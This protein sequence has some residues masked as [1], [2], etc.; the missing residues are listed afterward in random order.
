M[1]LTGDFSLQDV[2]DEFGNNSKPSPESLVQ[3][4]TDIFGSANPGDD[5]RNFTNT[6]QPSASFDDVINITSDSFQPELTVDA[7]GVL[8]DVRYLIATE[9]LTPELFSDEQDFLDSVD[10]T[11]TF[12]NVG[13]SI[14]A[15]TFNSFIVENLDDDTEYYIIAQYRNNFISNPLDYKTTW[16][17][18]NTGLDY[19]V[20]T[21]DTTSTTTTTVPFT[22]TIS[23]ASQTVN[24][25]VAVI[26]TVN[27]NNIPNDATMSYEV[28]SGGSDVSP[29]TGTFTITVTSG[30]T[31]T[32]NFSFN[33][34]ND[35]LTEGPESFDV[36]VSYLG[37]VLDTATLNINDTSTDTTTTTTTTL[38]PNY[39]S[40]NSPTTANE[41]Q[42]VTF[43]LQSTNIPDGTTVPYNTNGSTID[44][45]D[46]VT[47]S[48]PLSGT[49]TM[50]NNVGTLTFKLREDVLTEGSEKIVVNLAS[51][52]SNGI[53]D[54]LNV[55][56]QTIINDTSIPPTI[57]V[58]AKTLNSGEV[59]PNVK[60]QYR[61][62]GDPTI[63][64]VYDGALDSN[65]I[66]RGND[67]TTNISEGDTVEFFTDEVEDLEGS[68]SDCP[69]SIQTPNDGGY[70]ITVTNTLME[71]YLTIDAQ[72]AA[73]TT[74]TTTTTTT[75]GPLDFVG[76]IGLSDSS[77]NRTFVCYTSRN[78]DYRIQN[79]QSANT[80]TV[81]DILSQPVPAPDGSITYI[82]FTP[83][84]PLIIGQDV[85]SG[86]YINVNTSGEVTA[87]NNC[88]VTTT[89]TTTTTSTTTTTTTTLPGREHFISANETQ[90]S[91]NSSDACN[92]FPTIA[93]YSDTDGVANISLDDVIY[94]NPNLS[95]GTEFDGGNEPNGLW[96]G[97][98]DINGNQSQFTMRIDNNG[99]V[100][101]IIDCS[102][103]TTTTT[104]TTTTLSEVYEISPTSVTM[105]EGTAQIFEI[106][107]TN[108]PNGTTIYWTIDGNPTSDFTA[109]QG[110]ETI[111]TQFGNPSATFGVFTTNDSTTE[112][113]ENFN[114]RIRTGGFTGTIVD[115]AT[116]TVNDT[117]TTP[118][119]QGLT[120][121]SS[122][123][124]SFSPT[125]ACGFSLTE[126]Y[127]HDGTGT[128]PSIGDLVYSNSSG[129]SFLSNGFYQV[130]FNQ[131]IQVSS[132]EVIDKGLC[133]DLGPGGLGPI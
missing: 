123:T 74:T 104:T 30:T 102:G 4:H 115:T 125:N 52:D 72:N 38:P 16:G 22:A 99:V 56:S 23:P 81:G 106:N 43:T 68:L 131:Y 41:G 117:S 98:S 82:T 34:D 129:T 86:K 40:F 61:V 70:I 118:T 87:I 49:I 47:P 44:S 107:T 62:S 95:G 57:K 35:F 65:C 39:T 26:W 36:R 119:T 25:G 55:S 79:P 88:P 89:T 27:T 63:R 78:T 75:I 14:N 46:L 3:S 132:G 105:N 29:S 84:N 5:L 127:Y 133:S 53:T 12:T 48:S 76:T 51:Q 94:R 24:E 37:D 28:V 13:S 92:S 2:I 17:N 111:D 33:T 11:T 58:Y 8:T 97:M 31:G 108:V 90:G 114:L 113:T 71:V 93:V 101:E 42:D 73:P 77:S 121:Y 112:G 45:N 83:A 19:F 7:N 60:I 128:E 80:I 124:V 85:I 15:T 103:V 122:S 130:E 9:S 32:G 10:I 18:G 100:K 116:I 110:T 59:D 109:T 69:T 50:D 66:Q 120:S 126:T 1:P 6:G 21:T 64:T 91:L 96:Y 20:V 54:G 67:I